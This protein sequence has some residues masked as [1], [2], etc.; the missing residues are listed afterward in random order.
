MN[1][2]EL[3]LVIPSYLEEENLRLLIPRLQN[4]LN[5]LNIQ[6]EILIIDTMLPM[7]NTKTVCAENGAIYINREK[8]NSYG[9]AVR[10]GISRAQGQYM[11]FMDADGSHSP[12]FI[13]EM[14]LSRENN[15]VVVASRY[16]RGGG[17]DNNQML[18]IMSH[19][20]NKMYSWFLQIGCKDVSNSF[21]LY[22]SKPLKE[23]TLK[24]NNFDIIEE[25]LVKLKNRNHA[26][27]IKEIPYHFKERMFG[28]TKRNLI[29][30][31][32]SYLLTLIKLKYAKE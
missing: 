18:K 6:Y 24:S 22:R 9:D 13:K 7:D 11:L 27:K 16:I 21:K 12:E 8:G 25:I 17:S 10:T 1:N 29:A 4:V 15:D 2:I 23:I 31:S 20:V 30:F 3:S 32:F 26:L 19:F 28:H 5:L 14:Y